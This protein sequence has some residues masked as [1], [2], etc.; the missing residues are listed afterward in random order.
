MNGYESNKF[1]SAVLLALL[2]GMFASKIADM[3]VSPNHLDKNVYIVHGVSDSSS[4]T[5]ESGPA[6]GSEP[7]EPLLAKADIANGEKVSKKCLQCHV[8]EKDGP[9]KIGPD[10][11]GIVGSKI[12]SK[13]GFAYSKA[14]Q[15]IGGEWTFENL[16]K[17]LFKPSQ[18]VKGTKMSFAGIS[19]AQDRADMIAYLNKNSDSP[20]PLPTAAPAEQAPAPAEPVK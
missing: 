1:A 4:A 10:L 6:P 8:F 15:S 12:A 19:N 2:V 14:M 18:F 7:L 20:K 9:N 3:A 17:L 5:S 13:A 11:Y 16:N